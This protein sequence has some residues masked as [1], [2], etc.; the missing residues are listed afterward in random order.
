MAKKISTLL[1]IFLPFLLQAQTTEDAIRSYQMSMPRVSL[2]NAKYNSLL[3]SEFAKKKL[4]YDGG[5]IYL[6]SFKAQNKFEVWV[7]NRNVDTYQLF[8]TYDVCALSGVLGPKRYEGDRQVP[9]GLYFLSD[10]NPKSDFYLSMLVNYPNYSDMVL[11][12]KDRP[13]GDIYIHGGCVTVGCLPMTNSGIE[14]IYTLC[15]NARLNGQANIPVHI[16][17]TK[18]D[19]AGLN[20]LGREYR[21]ETEKQ[22]FWVNIKSAYDY[23]ERNRKLLP[24]MY[25]AEGRYIF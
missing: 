6:R 7:K 23:F 5:L 15:L 8:K 2:A 19:K 25:N 4:D 13:G 21:H 24:V 11:G 16:F 18:F 1:L 20:F 17:P 3:R 14:E 10:F 22:K 9:E 12:N